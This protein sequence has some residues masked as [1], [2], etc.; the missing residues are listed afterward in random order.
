MS[1]QDSHLKGTL[2]GVMGIGTFI[3]V[4]WLLIFVLY[5]ARL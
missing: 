2:V 5:L 3:V 4:S 1:K